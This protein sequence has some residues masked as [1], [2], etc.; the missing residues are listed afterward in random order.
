[1]V[2]AQKVEDRGV[3]VV[4]VDRF[5]DGLEAELVGGA[6]DRSPL[7]AAAGQPGGEAVVVVV[8]AVYLPLV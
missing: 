1:V 6:M 5:L 2:E 4:D 8:A 3:Q 7:H